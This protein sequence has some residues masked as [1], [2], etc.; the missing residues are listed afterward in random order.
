M[1]I[2]ITN[3]ER[4]TDISADAK[5]NKITHICCATCSAVAVQPIPFADYF[6][7][8]PIQIYMGS[9]I[10]AIREVPMSDAD[11]SIVMKEIF[12]ALG[13]GFVAQQ[14]ALGVWKFV[15]PGASGFMTI[16]IVYGLTFAIMRVM[17]SYFIAKAAKIVLTQSEM[18]NIWKNSIAESDRLHAEK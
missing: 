6:I 18:R 4:M 8:T 2:E 13:M 14:V 1:R 16:P 10:A 11:V 17:D 9:R 15:I 7:L 3:I 12:G 5:V